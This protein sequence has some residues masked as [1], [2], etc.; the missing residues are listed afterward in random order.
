MVFL[1]L[2]MVFFYVNYSS[3]FTYLFLFISLR[4]LEVY[5]RYI[6][7]KL[8]GLIWGTIFLFVALHCIK[9]S[10]FFIYLFIFYNFQFDGDCTT[11]NFY[12]SYQL[13]LYSLGNYCSSIM[14]PIIHLNLAAFSSSASIIH[15]S[16]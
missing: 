11:S 10:W 4:N 13:V 9:M 16:C 8:L 2:Q 7:L 5:C 14:F 6:C 3:V 1:F 15:V 12:C